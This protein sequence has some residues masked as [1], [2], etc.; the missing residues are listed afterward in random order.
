M[1]EPCPLREED[2]RG[3]AS[4]ELGSDGAGVGRWTRGLTGSVT[5]PLRERFDGGGWAIEK[6]EWLESGLQDI[7]KEGGRRKR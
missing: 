1:S 6:E 5:R 7:I 2:C 3:E 4:A